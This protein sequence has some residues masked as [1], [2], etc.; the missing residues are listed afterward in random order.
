[1]TLL[2]PLRFAVTLRYAFRRNGV[3]TPLLK[4]RRF[5]ETF[6]H[7]FAFRNVSK[8]NQNGTPFETPL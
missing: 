6:E 1:M 2:T 4:R 3:I 5:A 8:R 7:R